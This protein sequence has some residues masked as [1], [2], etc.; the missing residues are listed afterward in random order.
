MIG[1]ASGKRWLMS[2]RRAA[3]EAGTVSG[4]ESDNRGGGGRRGM[5]KIPEDIPKARKVHG[6]SRLASDWRSSRFWLMISAPCRRPVGAVQP[7][8]LQPTE[9]MRLVIF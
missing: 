8:A 4:D 5:R 7:L 3:T 9:T 1:A 6:I 2:A